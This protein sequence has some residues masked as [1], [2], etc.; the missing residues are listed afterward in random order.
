MGD[1]YDYPEDLGMKSVVDF[2]KHADRPVNEPKTESLL[3]RLS[4]MLA[5][6][7]DKTLTWEE[8]LTRL[9]NEHYYEFKEFADE[10]R[11]MSTKNNDQE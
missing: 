11:D 5:K 2:V 1:I 9:Y 8:A 7:Y 6:H 10:I 4:G 3:N